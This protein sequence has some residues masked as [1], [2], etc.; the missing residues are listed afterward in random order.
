MARTTGCALS[1]RLRVSSTGGEHERRKKQTT[2][3]AFREAGET[4]LAGPCLLHPAR[5]SFR[6]YGGK[7]LNLGFTPHDSRA[8][9]ERNRELFLKELGVASGRRSW[10][11]ISLRQIHSDLIH[12]VDAV[13]AQLLVGDGLVTDTP[14]LVLAVQTADCLPIILADRKRRAVECFSRWLARHGQAHREKGVGEMRKVSGGSAQ[15][16]RSNWAGRCKA[17]ATT[18][19]K[20]CVRNSRCQF[21]YASSLFREVKESDP[22]REKYPLLFSDRRAAP[23]HT[24]CRRDSFSILVEANAANCGSGVLAKNI[25]APAL[26]RHAIPSNC[27]ASARRRA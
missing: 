9:V 2:T 24:N 18:W 12:R 5:R 23:G 10:P 16:D 21:A 25:D 13:T 4:A 6:V 19:A 20:K 7:A 14:G 17:A 15:P 26:V 1:Y 3:I 8:A 11:L 27:S 22:V